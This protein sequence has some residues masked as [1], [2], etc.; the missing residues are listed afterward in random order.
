LHYSIITLFCANFGHRRIY[1]QNPPRKQVS[2]RSDM[3]SKNSNLFPMPTFLSRPYRSGTQKAERTNERT[4]ER[5]N[6]VNQSS[7]LSKKSSEKG[8]RN[9]CWARANQQMINL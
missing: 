3:R 2:Y 8:K 7:V 6:D 4:N 5:M 1:P 9:Q